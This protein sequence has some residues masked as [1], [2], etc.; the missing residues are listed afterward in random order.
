VRDLWKRR[1]TAIGATAAAI[2]A[3]REI[4]EDAAARLGVRRRSERRHWTAFFVGL[5][6]GAAAG[7]AIA[8]LTTP[9]PGREMRDE[10]AGKARETA[11]EWVPLFQREPT[12]GDVSTP[13]DTV[14]AQATPIEPIDTTP[15]RDETI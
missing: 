14:D 5:L 15:E 1:S 10:L 4:V 9:K 13:A 11:G 3:G 6:L 12:N 2:P 8:I 7:A